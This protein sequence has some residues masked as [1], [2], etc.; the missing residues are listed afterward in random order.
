MR[1]EVVRE[2]F[3]ILIKSQ[4]SGRRLSSCEIEITYAHKM[5]TLPFLFALFPYLLPCFHPLFKF[6]RPPNFFH[7]CNQSC[8]RN[9][10]VV[11]QLNRF[12]TFLDEAGCSRPSGT[13]LATIIAIALFT[14]MGSK[15]KKRVE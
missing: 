6:V 9:A 8:R 14:G 15:I 4:S 11:D 2:K 7:I 12:Q 5:K 3:I 1:D 10:D 13:A